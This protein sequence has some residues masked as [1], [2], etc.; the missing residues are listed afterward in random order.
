MTCP[1][2]LH[3]VV[4][5]S[6][7]VLIT[8]PPV[9]TPEEPLATCSCDVGSSG[10]VPDGKNPA[11]S[12]A[13][14]GACLHHKKSECCRHDIVA[15]LVLSAVSVPGFTHSVI[16]LSAT[17]QW[18]QF[19]SITCGCYDGLYGPDG[20]V[21]CYKKVVSYLDSHE[22]FDNG[23]RRKGQLS[24]TASAYCYRIIICNRHT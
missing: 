23:A 16:R 22:G 11:D 19:D 9:A 24:T 13:L 21:S 5:S 17:A 12:H 14:H 8:W 3:T 6:T 20:L 15:V 7:L 1:L 10:C 4:W 2:V 18:A